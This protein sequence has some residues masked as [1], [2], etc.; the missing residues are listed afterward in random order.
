MSIV[1]KF[2][3]LVKRFQSNTKGTVGIM[4]G[5]SAVPLVLAAGVAVEFCPWQQG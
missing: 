3:G 1:K 4:L 2:T 5:L